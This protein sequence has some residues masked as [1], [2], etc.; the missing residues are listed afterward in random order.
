MALIVQRSSPPDSYAST[1]PVTRMT[2]RTLTARPL[3]SRRS[4]V[5]R[6]AVNAIAVSFGR[7][8]GVIV[9][10]PVPRGTRTVIP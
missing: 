5:T 8:S 4:S 3:E 10:G 1:G 6:S 7:G 2:S 9:P